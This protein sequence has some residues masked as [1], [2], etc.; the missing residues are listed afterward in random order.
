MRRQ[1]RTFAGALDAA[2]FDHVHGLVHAIKGVA[3]NLAAKDLQVQSGALEKLVKHMD[4]CSPPPTV[5][6]NRAHAAFR[7]SLGRALDAV[8]SLIPAAVTPAAPEETPASLSSALAKEAAT[9]LREAAELGDVFGLAGICSE[10]SAKYEV[11]APYAA[12]VARLADDFDF[13]GIL[14]LVDEFEH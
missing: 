5:E 2:D 8:R 10:L 9:R 7:E 13:D 12:R 3:G 1:R 11:F 14:K 6:L 4:P